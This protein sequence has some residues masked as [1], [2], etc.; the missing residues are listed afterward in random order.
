MFWDTLILVLIAF[1]VFASLWELDQIR[2][3]LYKRP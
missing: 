1:G 2:Q 3:G